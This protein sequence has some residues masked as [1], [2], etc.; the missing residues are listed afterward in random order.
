[1]AVSAAMKFMR[2]LADDSFC[3]VKTD[4][5]LC[6]PHR[7]KATKM[8]SA[9]RTA[10]DADEPK[11]MA[12]KRTSSSVTRDAKYSRGWP[13]QCAS[14]APSPH[15]LASQTTTNIETVLCSGIVKLVRTSCSNA[16]H[17]ARGSLTLFVATK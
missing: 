1:M 11:S 4:A 17:Q 16:A 15:G 3:N 12:N 2:G 7:R 14:T 6:L 5:R 8:Q 10:C 9:S 13:L